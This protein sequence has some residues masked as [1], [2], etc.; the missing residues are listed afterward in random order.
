VSADTRRLSAL[1]PPLIGVRTEEASR[2]EEERKE[3]DKEEVEEK[4][5]K[6]KRE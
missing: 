3:K 4:Q 5:E 2:E 1:R 6:R